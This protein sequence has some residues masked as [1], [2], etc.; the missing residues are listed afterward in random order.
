MIIKGHIQRIIEAFDRQESK[1]LKFGEN[2]TRNV[3]S[4]ILGE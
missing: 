2:E 3:Y 4:H 1:K